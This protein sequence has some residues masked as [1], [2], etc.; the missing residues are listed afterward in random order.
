M[1]DLRRVVSL[2]SSQR[3]LLRLAQ[4]QAAQQVKAGRVGRQHLGRGID[5]HLDFIIQGWVET[6]EP[7]ITTWP[8]RMVP[9]SGMVI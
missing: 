4:G 9:I 6:R 1:G 8:A 5:A 2:D 3:L 7:K